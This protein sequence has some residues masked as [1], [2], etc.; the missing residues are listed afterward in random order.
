MNI[1]ISFYQPKPFIAPNKSASPSANGVGMKPEQVEA[2]NHEL[3]QTNTGTL[4]NHVDKGIGLRNVNARIKNLYGKEY[5]IQVKSKE[6][7]YTE[8][9]IR[10]HLL[11]EDKEV[12]RY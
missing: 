6:G 4:V 7:C 8:V 2:L 12:E 3:A 11:E 10:I 9:Q 1:T 5:G